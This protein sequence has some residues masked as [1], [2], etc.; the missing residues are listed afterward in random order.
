M[1]AF[2]MKKMYLFVSNKW[3]SVFSC[4]SA[5]FQGDVLTC[6]LVRI[7]IAADIYIYIYIALVK[8]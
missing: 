6:P 4:Y 3:D 5:I 1:K 8:W 7:V 2:V